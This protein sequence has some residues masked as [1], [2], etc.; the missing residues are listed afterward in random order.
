MVCLREGEAVGEETVGEENEFG[1]GH[2]AWPGRL[3][4]RLRS[5]L[6][7]RL[8]LSELAFAFAFAFAFASAFASFFAFAFV[9][10]GRLVDSESLSP[11]LDDKSLPCVYKSDGHGQS[12]GRH[13]DEVEGGNVPQSSHLILSNGKTSAL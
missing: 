9:C 13:V 10:S 3:R 8:R 2:I 6:R 4:L 12:T 5:R 1:G 11:R 7:L